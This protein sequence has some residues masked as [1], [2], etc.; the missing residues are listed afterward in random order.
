M[1]FDLLL[2]RE[3]AEMVQVAEISRD[4]RLPATRYVKT[5]GLCTGRWLYVRDMIQW[6]VSWY[7]HYIEMCPHTIN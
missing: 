1:V 5:V 7:F 3:V 4:G 2:G 6:A